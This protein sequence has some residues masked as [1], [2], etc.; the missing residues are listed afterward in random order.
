MEDIVNINYQTEEPELYNFELIPILEKA[1]GMLSETQLQ[2]YFSDLLP[3]VVSAKARRLVEKK[4]IFLL[5]QE[6]KKDPIY[7]A[8]SHLLEETWRNK[9]IRYQKAFW[10]YLD[11]RKKYGIQIFSIIR[12]DIDSLA[13]SFQFKE[14]VY[15]ILYVPKGSEP[16]LRLLR[17]QERYMPEN[18]IDAF[19]RIAIIENTDQIPLIKEYEIS[20]LYL[21][22]KISES[23]TVSYKKIQ[24]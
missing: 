15:D 18:E 8:S 9:V 10:L 5:D 4:E 6:K 22:A 11:F 13:L 19:H 24:K 21:F 14:N 23:G 2:M 1:G 3:Q 20:G 16:S 17:M 12:S 7:L